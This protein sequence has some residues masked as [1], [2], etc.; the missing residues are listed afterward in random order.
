MPTL[1]LSYMQWNDR[2][3]S[4]FFQPSMAGRQVYLYVTEELLMD[5]GAESGAGVSEFVEAVKLGS[6]GTYDYGLCQKAHHSFLLWR[7]NRKLPYP[8]T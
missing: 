2:L 1:P 7:R 8:P 3:A 5:L 4:H 6:P